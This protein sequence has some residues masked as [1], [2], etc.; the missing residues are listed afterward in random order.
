MIRMVEIYETKAKQAAAERSI[1]A[2][3]FPENVRDRLI[4]GAQAQNEEENNKLTFR[5]TDKKPSTS[6]DQHSS[7]GL[8][9]SKPIADFHPEATLMFADL[10]GFSK[11][12]KTWW[13]HSLC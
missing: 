12:W 10:V 13:H 2:S 5:N 6:V 9:G 1:V 8:F 7:E 3:L 4:E 11:Y